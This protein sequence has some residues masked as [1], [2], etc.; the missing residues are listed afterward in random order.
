VESACVVGLPDDEWGEIV[1]AVIT[2]VTGATTMLAEELREMCSRELARPKVPQKWFSSDEMPTTAS[3][4]I[5]KFAVQ[6]S[7]AN[8]ELQSLATHSNTKG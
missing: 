8:A 1:A 5:Q 3:G 7:A 2:P 6:K 4:K